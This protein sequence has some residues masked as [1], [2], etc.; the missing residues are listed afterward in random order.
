MMWPR[1]LLVDLV[2]HRGER[3]RLARARR[4]GDQHQ[5]A[6]TLGHLR[7]DVG[8]AELLERLDVERDLPDHHR[9]AAALLEAVA[10]EA[11]EVLDAEREVE[12]V[13]RLEPLLLV[14]GQ[15]RVGELQRVLRRQHDIDVRRS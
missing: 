5:P 1:T 4:A 14:L 2:D 15:D 9:H 11:R 12:L 6:R 7:D 8:E 13:L 10:A 3:R